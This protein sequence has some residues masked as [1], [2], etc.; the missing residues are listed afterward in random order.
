[1]VAL[2][3]FEINTIT[4]KMTENMNVIMPGAFNP[5][6]PLPL[7]AANRSNVYPPGA[8]LNLSVL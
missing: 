3:N 8:G 2:K 1:M 4:V 5:T 6:S 7:C